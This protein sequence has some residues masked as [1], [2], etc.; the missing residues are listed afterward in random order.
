MRPQWLFSPS[1]PGLLSRWTL[2][3]PYF[4]EPT[5]SRFS[6]HPSILVKCSLKRL[7]ICSR[8]LALAGLTLF[9]LLT[10]AI[11][12]S[13]MPRQAIM[14]SWKMSSTSLRLCRYSSDSYSALSI[15][16]SV[17]RPNFD[18][19]NLWPNVGINNQ[20]AASLTTLKTVENPT[21]QNAIK[22]FTFMKI[23][24]YNLTQ[25]VVARGGYCSW[26]IE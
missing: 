17:V 22:I 6:Q 16:S 18:S 23:W 26:L 14:D 20:H 21:T 8:S 11:I 12:S 13:A 2:R 25:E 5:R 19:L 3:S 9:L 7:L 10:K 24:N 4:L 1:R 15:E